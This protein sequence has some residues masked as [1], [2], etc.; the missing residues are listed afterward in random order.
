MILVS[1]SNIQ[2]LTT[3]IPAML[4]VIWT[5]TKDVKTA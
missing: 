4:L 1:F 3:F 2:N 5:T